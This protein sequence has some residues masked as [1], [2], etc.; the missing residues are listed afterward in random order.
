MLA[1]IALCIATVALIRAGKR[2]YAWVTLVP[3]CVVTITTMA[4]SVVLVIR[5]WNR[6]MTATKAV[7][8][9]N[10]LVAA[11]LIVGIVICTAVI[12]VAALMRSRNPGP[13]VPPGHGFP[14]DPLSDEAKTLG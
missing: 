1:V 9:V 13:T 14:V 12:M 10:A 11:S 2:K 8:R 3:M 5:F 4:A 6:F 7:E